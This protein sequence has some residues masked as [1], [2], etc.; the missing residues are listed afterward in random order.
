MEP[1]IPKEIG[2]TIS[3]LKK[4]KVILYPTDT[5]W[6]I[7]CDAYNSKAIQKL[8]Q[9]K[10]RSENKSL[11]VLLHNRNELYK[12]LY[13]VPDIAFDLMDKASGP[14]TI[15]YHEAKDNLKHVKAQDGTVAI[16]IIE[17]QF[18][19][20]LIK[21]LGRPLISTSA[22]L[23][24]NPTPATFRQIDESIKEGVDYVVNLF[25]A[26]LSSTKASTLVKLEKN[27]TFKVL[28]S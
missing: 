14:L 21:K 2:R 18:C 23:S 3:L 27:N 16:R 19:T 15:I 5:V 1:Q 28:R 8:Y 20:P 12:Y 25:Q 17:D 6:A 24:G 13:H 7:G 9:I 11:I 26:K 10:Q 4:G 22:N